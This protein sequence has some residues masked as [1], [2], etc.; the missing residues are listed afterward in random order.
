MTIKVTAVKDL[1]SGSQIG[2]FRNVKLSKADGTGKKYAEM[3]FPISVLEPSTVTAKCYTLTYG[4]DN[5]VF[6][7]DITGG[8]LD[9]TPVTRCNDA[10]HSSLYRCA[11]FISSL[12]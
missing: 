2:Y 1:A 8:V 5:P 11:A 3:S 9:G 6:G 7:Y 12:L 4:D 10:S